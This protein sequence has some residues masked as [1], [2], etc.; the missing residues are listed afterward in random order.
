MI[1]VTSTYQF[2]PSDWSTGMQYISYCTLNIAL[3]ELPKIVE[4]KQV[5]YVW[6]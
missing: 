6:N 5:V 3:Y 1:F 4:E 2:F